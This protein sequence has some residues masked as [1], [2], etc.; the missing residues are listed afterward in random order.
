MSDSFY[1]SILWT[2]TTGASRNFKTCTLQET[3]REM[4]PRRMR[5]ARKVARREIKKET[6]SKTSGKSTA[7][8][9]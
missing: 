6:T 8:Y 7:G 9:N 3:L 5:W 4:N 1:T 2:A